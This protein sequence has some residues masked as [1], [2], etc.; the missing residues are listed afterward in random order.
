[1]SLHRLEYAT[2]ITA[3]R[4][5]QDARC[6]WYRQQLGD[7]RTRR[8]NTD[9]TALPPGARRIRHAPAPAHDRRTHPN[10]SHRVDAAQGEGLA[11]LTSRRPPDC[12]P[13]VLSLPGL[14][15]PGTVPPR[16]SILE[17]RDQHLTKIKEARHGTPL[18]R[19]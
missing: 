13:V 10:R 5:R 2:Q 16:S 8:N 3:R 15:S 14:S 7:R 18:R 12:R 1:V 4:R 6:H 9:A 11:D 17:G 19:L